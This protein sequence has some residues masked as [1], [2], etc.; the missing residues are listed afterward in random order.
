MVYGPACTRCFTSE[1]SSELCTICLKTHR[2]VGNNVASY[3]NFTLLQQV[4]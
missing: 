1:C 4:N 2:Y 3:M